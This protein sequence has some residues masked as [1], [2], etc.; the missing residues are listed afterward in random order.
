MG[1]LAEMVYFD[2]VA[3]GRKVSTAQMWKR[4]IERFE[5]VAGI[6]D[7]YDR[8]D[9]LAYVADLRESGL[10]QN[11]INIMLRPVKL[12]AQ[13][14]E[15]D[16]PRIAMPKVRV[17][18]VKKPTLSY[19]EVVEMI[20]KGK[21]VLSRKQLAYLALST[22]Y[23]LRREEM[24]NLDGR[25]VRRGERLTV[26]TLKGGP[27]TTHRI[28]GEIKRYLKG[29]EPAVDIREMSNEF[30][31][32]CKAVGVKRKD[33][34]GWHSVRRCLATELEVR[35]GSN[36]SVSR[37]MRWSDSSMK[38]ELAMLATYAKKDQGKIDEEMFK[39]HP[40]LEFWSDGR[41]RS[42]ELTRF[43]RLSE[44]FSQDELD[45]LIRKREEVV[46]LLLRSN[47]KSLK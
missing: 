44:L 27:E 17:S 3:R 20:K 11:S 5:R 2:L 25:E 12:L 47:L 45:E 9:V 7:K 35:A 29:F 33:G 38:G 15:W 43:E 46:S 34:Y 37:F 23:G 4:C 10:C 21:K 40:F 28:P 1:K 42:D 41:K 39:V 26:K 16:F 8:A 18:D 36:V 24:V 19:D 14:Q 6:K 13:I 30:R 22:V 31:R 32:I